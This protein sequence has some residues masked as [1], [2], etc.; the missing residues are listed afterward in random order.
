MGIAGT[1]LWIGSEA[2]AA[3]LPDTLQKVKPSV[4]GVGTFASLRQPRSI[5]YGTGWVVADGR[6]AIT[7]QHVLRAKLD[8]KIRELHAVFV[9]RADKEP[10]AFRAEPVVC[11]RRHDLCLLRF[12]GIRLPALKLG[13]AA[14]VREGETYALTGFPIGMVLGLHPATHQGIVASITPIA[15]PATPGSRL[16]ERLLGHL[17]TPFKVFQLDAI[18]YPGNSGSPLY[19]VD[20]GRVVGVVNS[21]FVK[22]SKENAL[23]HP[24]GISYAIPVTHV[25][26]L[27]QKARLKP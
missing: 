14:Q 9:P 5:F 13:H 21:V 18:A 10:K 4:L 27:L 6:H 26:D 24:S 12:E 25:Y 20:S 7:N 16:D 3:G 15:I 11:D 23:E 19:E 1:T 17:S 2:Q 22:G 8:T